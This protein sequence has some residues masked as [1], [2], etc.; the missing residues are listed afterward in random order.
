M[1]HKNQYR[2]TLNGDSSLAKKRGRPRLYADAAAR[3]RAQRARERASRL[4]QIGGAPAPVVAV[5]VDHADPV[6][7]LA[8]WAAETLIV[9][10]GH[11]LAA[12]RWRCQTSR[13]RG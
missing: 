2:D 1:C 9:P 6:G 7:V 10:D 4:H 12:G 13:S 8:T 3:K 11:P 5:V